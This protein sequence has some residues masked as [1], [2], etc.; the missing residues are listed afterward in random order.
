VTL[1][2]DLDE[3]SQTSS[4]S[5]GLNPSPLTS[6][7]GT[8]SSPSGSL[9]SNSNSASTSH[10]IEGVVGGVLGLAIVILVFLHYRLRRRYS[11]AAAT[12]TTDDM[13]SQGHTIDDDQFSW[14]SRPQ[15]FEPPH[16]TAPISVASMN[17]HG[18]VADASSTM[19]LTR[20]S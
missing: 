3:S 11:S 18:V 4:P 10:I 5:L 1:R 14:E 8:S 6:A 19:T 16:I 7:T 2:A 9:N 12:I 15:E 13:L 20:V 17:E